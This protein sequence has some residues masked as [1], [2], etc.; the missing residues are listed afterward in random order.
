MNL[1]GDIKS[2]VV[3]EGMIRP[4]NIKIEADMSPV[5][6]LEA[7]LSEGGKIGGSLSAVGSMSGSLSNPIE[8]SVSD[9]DGPYEFTPSLDTQ[10]INIGHKTA[11]HDIIISPIPHNYGLITWDGQKLTVS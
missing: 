7:E 11:D 2:R 5:A 9:Y 1:S 8:I 4:L 10:R 3:L 6:E